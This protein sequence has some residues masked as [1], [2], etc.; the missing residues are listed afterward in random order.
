MILSSDEPV[1]CLGVAGITYRVF[2]V[3][4]DARVLV[5]RCYVVDRRHVVEG[6]RLKD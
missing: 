6:E 2:A 3:A 1:Y 5:S 4:E